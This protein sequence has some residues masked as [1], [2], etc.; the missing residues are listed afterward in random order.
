MMKK[1]WRRILGASAALVLSW[2]VAATAQDLRI[3]VGSEPTTLDPQ[4]ASDG[5]ERLVNQN[6]Y[7]P[8]VNRDASGKFIGLNHEGIFY[9]PESLLEPIRMTRMLEKES[10]FETGDPYDFIECVQTIFPVDGFAKPVVAG[11][12]IPSYKVLDVYGRPWAQI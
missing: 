4:L 11:S 6:I 3:A 1:A 7:E 5:G 12:V 9:D 8:L 10:G 2:S